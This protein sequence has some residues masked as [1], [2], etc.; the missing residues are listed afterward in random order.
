MPSS[1][2]ACASTATHEKRKKRNKPLEVRRRIFPTSRT[3]GKMISPLFARCG[4]VAVAAIFTAGRPLRKSGPSASSGTIIDTGFWRGHYPTALSGW[5]RL[6]RLHAS[7]WTANG[8]GGSPNCRSPLIL[9]AILGGGGS[10]TCL[11]AA[12]TIFKLR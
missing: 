12:S 6:P 5:G 9:N 4:M 2:L 7:S 1:R 8:S 11:H 3:G 10:A